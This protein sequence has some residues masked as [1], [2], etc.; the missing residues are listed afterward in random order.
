VD[1]DDHAC[2]NWLNWSNRFDVSMT[3]NDLCHWCSRWYSKLCSLRDFG[4]LL[5]FPNQR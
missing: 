5:Q 2:W 1:V 4:K 3:I